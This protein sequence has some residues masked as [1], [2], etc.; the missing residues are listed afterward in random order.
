MWNR[1]SCLFIRLADFKPGIFDH[2]F[3]LFKILSAGRQI[4]ETAAPKETKKTNFVI[5]AGYS[6]LHTP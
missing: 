4:P 1:H 5:C 3:I 6:N 2:F